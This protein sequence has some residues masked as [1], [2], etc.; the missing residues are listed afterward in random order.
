MVL[1]NPCEAHGAGN[2]VPLAGIFAQD[3][4]NVDETLGIGK[5]EGAPKLR[6]ENAKNSGVGTD[7]QSQRE[8]DD[9]REAE[10]FAK[11]AATVTKV[12]HD[13]FDRGQALPITIGFLA[14]L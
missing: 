12:A 4:V 5:R 10:I 11:H 13:R 14:L 7:A 9:E 1:R 8:N 2:R 6:F 3:D